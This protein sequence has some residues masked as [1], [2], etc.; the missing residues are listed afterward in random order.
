VKI[1]LVRIWCI[2]GQTAWS[3]SVTEE[4]M[5]VKKF[6][7][8]QPKYVDTTKTKLQSTLVKKEERG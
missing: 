8:F 3:F 5:H 7:A 1:L 4:K 6:D 2:H